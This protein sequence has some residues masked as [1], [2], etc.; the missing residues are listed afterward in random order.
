MVCSVQLPVGSSEKTQIAYSTEHYSA[1]L[2][3]DNLMMCGDAWPTSS[4]WPAEEV[5][6][7]SPDHLGCTCIARIYMV[8]HCNILYCK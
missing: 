8:A 3:P 4:G 1:K 7:K 6:Y 2:F 5:G